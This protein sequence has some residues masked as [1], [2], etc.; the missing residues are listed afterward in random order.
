MNSI[1]DTCC[2]P[3]TPT[4]KACCTREII[5]GRVRN[6]LLVVLLAD[7]LT[8]SAK[9]VQKGSAQEACRDAC[10]S[11]KEDLKPKAGANRDSCCQSIDNTCR[12]AC[13]SKDVMKPAV[14][15]SGDAGACRDACCSKDNTGTKTKTKTPAAGACRDACCSKKEGTTTPRTGESGDRDS[16]CQA[17]EAEP[18]STP[19]AP[20]TPAVVEA[21]PAEQPPKSCCQKGCCSK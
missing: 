3:K 5:K 17:I 14:A 2:V 18:E 19:S 20:T 4:G 12:D 10:C 6:T 7:L 1:K 16:C 9:K 11:K 21:T 15:A 8:Y 13:C